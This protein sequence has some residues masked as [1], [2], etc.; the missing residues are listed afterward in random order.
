VDSRWFKEDRALPKEDQ[1]Q[2]I[3]E[4]K[5]AIAAATIIRRRLARI[6]EEEI[7]KTYLTEEDIYGLDWQQKVL[8]QIA[9]RKTLRE[10]YNLIHNIG[11]DK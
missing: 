4:S 2:A 7:E 3:E 6:L 8:F 9:R 5:K 11:H 10:V 1:A